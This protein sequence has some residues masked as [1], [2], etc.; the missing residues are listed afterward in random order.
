SWEMILMKLY[1]NNK[2]V[3]NL[4]N[5]IEMIL[6]EGVKRGNF[7]EVDYLMRALRRISTYEGYRVAFSFDKEFKIGDEE[8]KFNKEDKVV[9]VLEG[10]R[11][12]FAI[13]ESINGVTKLHV[14]P[15]DLMSE[16][17][18]ENGLIAESNAIVM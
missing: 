12:I 15:Y 14:D 2:D 6:R 13:I 10:D 7:G 5:G 17:Q 18:L 4:R 1:N 11:V 8:F 16:R 3:V 9:A